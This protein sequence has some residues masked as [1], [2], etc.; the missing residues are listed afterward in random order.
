MHAMHGLQDVGVHVSALVSSWS[1][2][3]QGSGSVMD[4]Q[5]GL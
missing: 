3:G 5:L 2:H 1:S 4:V